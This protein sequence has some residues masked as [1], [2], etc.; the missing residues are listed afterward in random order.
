MANN[1]ETMTQHTPGPWK[2]D[3]RGDD[4]GLWGGKGHSRVL[5]I[6][7]GVIPQNADARLIA[8]APAMLAALKSLTRLYDKKLMTPVNEIAPAWESVRAILRAVEGKEN[9]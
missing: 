1:R 3:Q 2:F 5:S 8:Q 7:S 4:Y 9:K 6:R